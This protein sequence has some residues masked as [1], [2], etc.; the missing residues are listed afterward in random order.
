MFRVIN[1]ERLEKKLEPW[2]VDKELI[3]R[4]RKQFNGTCLPEKVDGFTVV[5]RGYGPRE[6]SIP[7]KS[8]MVPEVKR[9]ACILGK[10]PGDTYFVFIENGSSLKLSISIF[11]VIGVFFLNQFY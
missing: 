9:A 1:K 7:P 2:K 11:A 3:E 5:T 4:F 6:T 8:L 10:C